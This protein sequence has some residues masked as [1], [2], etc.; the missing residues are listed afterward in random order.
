MAFN[1]PAFKPPTFRWTL[2]QTGS[3]PLVVPVPAPEASVRALPYAAAGP[4]FKDRWPATEAFAKVPGVSEWF[5]QRT[6]QNGPME[7]SEN[8]GEQAAPNS[9]SGKPQ[10]LPTVLPSDKP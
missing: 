8:S 3:E 6:G 2:P 10:W 1:L 4:G 7:L 5:A 9:G